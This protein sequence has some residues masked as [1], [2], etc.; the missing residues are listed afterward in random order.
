M[1]LASK[2]VVP[3]YPRVTK[4]LKSVRALSFDEREQTASEFARCLRVGKVAL[5]RQPR[6][7]PHVWKPTAVRAAGSPSD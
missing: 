2:P 6:R 5:P 7:A 1:A 4:S 3:T